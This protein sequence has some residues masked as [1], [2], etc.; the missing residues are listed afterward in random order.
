MKQEENGVAEV[1]YEAFM[2]LKEDIAHGYP[3]EDIPVLDPF[4]FSKCDVSDKHI[5]EEVSAM[6]EAKFN[7]ISLKGLSRY[8]ISDHKFEVISDSF[9]FHFVF[10]IRALSSTAEHFK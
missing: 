2:N 1:I 9:F 10:F 6:L 7:D 3:E 5:E 4:S 8:N